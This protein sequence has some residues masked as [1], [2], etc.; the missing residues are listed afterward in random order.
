VLLSINQNVYDYPYILQENVYLKKS[1]LAH[2]DV[3]PVKY[4]ML[5]TLPNAIRWFM[6]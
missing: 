5:L 1:F 6:L 4:W 2:T 3:K